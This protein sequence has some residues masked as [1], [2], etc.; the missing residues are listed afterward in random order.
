MQFIHQY[1]RG[2]V[3]QWRGNVFA[4]PQPQLSGHHLGML[5]S[6]SSVGTAAR[7]AQKRKREAEAESEG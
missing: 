3:V 2:V 7:V 4:T 6:V 5:D 1:G